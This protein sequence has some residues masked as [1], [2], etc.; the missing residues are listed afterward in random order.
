MKKLDLNEN[1]NDHSS[2]LSS[3]HKGLP[4]LKGQGAWAVATSLSGKK[5]KIKMSW[6][7]FLRKL[8]SLRMKWA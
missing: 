2:S 7:P 4:C 6:V 3:V 5:N 1:E 8:V